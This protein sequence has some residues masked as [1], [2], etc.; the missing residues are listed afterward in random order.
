MLAVFGVTRH[1]DRVENLPELIPCYR[2]DLAVCRYRRA[3]HQIA[4]PANSDTGKLNGPGQAS[5]GSVATRTHDDEPAMKYTYAFKPHILQKWSDRFL[6]LE[7]GRNKQ[8]RAVFRMNGNTCS[9]MGVRIVL[10]FDLTLTWQDGDYLIESG[11]VRPV[12]GETG[13][14]EM[15]EF[16][17]HPD[18]FWGQASSY[19][20]LQ[21]QFLDRVLGWNPDINP[22]GCLCERSHQDHKWR[23]VYQTIHFALKGNK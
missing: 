23:M 21:G 22:A 12:E 7:R 15:C 4:E 16:I 2:C 17:Q 11:R 1:I 8:T 18:A 5:K 3:P 6:D 10:D 9:N 14:Q 19:V 13:Y 20:P